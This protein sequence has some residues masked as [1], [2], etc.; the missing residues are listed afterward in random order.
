MI[1]PELQNM[2]I[3]LTPAYLHSSMAVDG[4]TGMDHIY[5]HVVQ[6]KLG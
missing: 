1:I 4:V 3:T 6:Q 2:N 5:R